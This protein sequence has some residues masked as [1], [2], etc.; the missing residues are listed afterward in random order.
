MQLLSQD[1]VRRTLG[2]A[3]D[4]LDGWNIP[5]TIDD[6]QGKSIHAQYLLTWLT[7]HHLEYAAKLIQVANKET[8]Q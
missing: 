7:Q 3:Q 8:H 6:G 4:E 1:D 2:L 5:W